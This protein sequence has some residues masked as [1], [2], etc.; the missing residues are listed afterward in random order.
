MSCA[1]QPAKHNT[2]TGVM[3]GNGEVL[4]LILIRSQ[5]YRSLNGVIYPNTE[6]YSNLDCSREPHET[7]KNIK[8]AFCIICPLMFFK[9]IDC[10]VH[11]Y[12]SVLVHYVDIL[13]QI[14][15]DKH[16]ATSVQLSTALNRWLLQWKYEIVKKRILNW[17]KLNW[18]LV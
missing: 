9:L 14:I 16:L 15:P 3:H 18:I 11:W 8:T 10:T 12:R 13:Y 1:L 7:Y 6:M 17:K 2:A 5:Y 4:I